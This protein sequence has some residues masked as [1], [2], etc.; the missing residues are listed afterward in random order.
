M[1]AEELTAVRA[2]SATQSA[3]DI[4]GVV[5]EQPAG[6]AIAALGAHPTLTR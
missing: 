6:A 5:D 4:A 1:T 3:T 2:S